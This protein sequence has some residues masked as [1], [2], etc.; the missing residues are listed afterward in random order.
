MKGSM[1]HFDGDRL[2]TAKLFGLPNIRV[3]LVGGR[4]G[5]DPPE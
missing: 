4:L 1:F 5:P 3:E 2:V